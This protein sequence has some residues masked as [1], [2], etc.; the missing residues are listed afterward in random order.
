MALSFTPRQAQPRWRLRLLRSDFFY[1]RSLQL[2][3]LVFVAILMSI[4]V[5]LALQSRDAFGHFG[6]GIITGTT[7]DPVNVVY[8]ALP[9]ILGTLLTSGLALLFALPIGL[10]T[11]IVLAE[12]APRWISRPLGT[13]VE[14]LAAVP[15]VVFGLWGL[16]VVSEWYRTSVQTNI[17]HVVGRNFPLFSGPALG[18]GALFAG[19]I[20]AAMILPTLTAV[21]RDVMVAVPQSQREAA[22]ALGATRWQV[23]RKAVIPAARAGILGAIVL[24]L[25]R[26]LGETIAVTMIIGGGSSLP[27]S[28]FAPI[29]TMASIIASEFNEATEPF[30]AAAI[31][32]VA[33]LLLTVGIVVNGIARLLVRTVDRRAGLLAT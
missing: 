5:S 25:G 11:A 7:W 3:G 31:A 26:A 21:S 17:Q 33:V 14:L 1:H 28:L 22:L 10:A 8:G 4:V 13:I 16:L 32:A 18:V 19:L 24:A 6:I 20:L 23:V 15:S 29:S 2:S 27:K 30:H 9:F 12:F